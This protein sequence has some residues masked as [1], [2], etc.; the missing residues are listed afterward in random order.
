MEL[1]DN[2]SFPYCPLSGTDIRY[3]S[4]LPYND[5]VGMVECQMWQAPLEAMKKYRALSYSWG[6]PP[7]THRILLAGQQ[8]PVT[9]NLSAYLHH[10]SRDPLVRSL[11]EKGLKFR[12]WIDAL[13]IDQDNMTERNAQVLRMRDI[14]SLSVVVIVWLG[15]EGEHTKV[16]M[17]RM[18]HVA[19]S[20]WKTKGKRPSE[21]P[22][23]YQEISKA[24]VNHP[25]TPEEI[26]IQTGIAD[27][28]ERAY[29]ARTWIIQEVAAS[30]KARFFCGTLELFARDLYEYITAG[31]LHSVTSEPDILLTK[32]AFSPALSRVALT[33]FRVKIN[34]EDKWAT[35]LENL[36][37]ISSNHL[38][39]DP[40]DKV[41]GLL[42]VSSDFNTGVIVPDYKLPVRDV[43]IN[44]VLAVIQKY[45][46][47]TIL[48]Q[49]IPKKASTLNLPSWVPDWSG[50]QTS[51]VEAEYLDVYVEDIDRPANYVYH[52]SQD[53]TLDSHP[54]SIDIPH[55][56]LSL[57][58][59]C[60]DSIV[61]TSDVM[62]FYNGDT[63]ETALE[64]MKPTLTKLGDSYS[65][66]GEPIDRAFR[67]T[68]VADFGVET[69]RA[70]SE[71]RGSQMIFP[72][73]D[74][75]VDDNG[76][77]WT[78]KDVS[79]AFLRSCHKKR[80]AVTQRG[81]MGLVRDETEP[82]DH[83]AILI[84]GPVVYVM[85]SVQPTPRQSRQS[86]RP[87]QEPS[88]N[89]MGEAYFHGVMDGEVLSLGELHNI[90]IL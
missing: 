36:L 51:E 35:R 82:G 2:Q 65:Q 26:S 56:I 73:D 79:R 75:V 42:G 86:T 15:E 90:R 14:Y 60:F 16:A 70:G 45:Q 23:G 62:D 66:T 7:T 83:L 85:R 61:E 17:N 72:T 43:Y 58:G 47:L 55:G 88:Y 81:L 78:Y 64:K 5:V 1:E 34:L 68:A 38:A 67:R 44:T 3:V 4:V 59:I 40:R 76:E 11:H 20:T 53:L 12:I 29:W 71:R 25:Q 32:E 54:W 28:Y 22:E 10:A 13:C 19:D 89:L 33:V 31:V 21:D 9:E 69:G 87:G 52:A 27:I 48:N 46:N 50:P 41:Y 49:C 80:F 63:W 8:F 18:S 37:E 57:S 6:A 74:P 77:E 24:L 30:K 84:G 39:K